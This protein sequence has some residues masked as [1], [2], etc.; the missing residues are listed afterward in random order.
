MNVTAVVDTA[1]AEAEPNAVKAL[2]ADGVAVASGGAGDVSGIRH[3]DGFPWDEAA[4]DARAGRQISELIDLPVTQSVPER[5]LNA[6]DLV[7]CRH[8]HTALVV[9]NHVLHAGRW[10]GSPIR[11]TAREIYLVDGYGADPRQLAS[12]LGQLQTSLGQAQLTTVPL[13]ML[14]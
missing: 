8:S 2:A 14:A 13:G 10:D 9:P 7:D 6:W 3:A 11:V 12:F 1:T 4:S 5:R